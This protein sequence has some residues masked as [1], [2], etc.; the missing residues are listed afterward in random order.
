MEN[1]FLVWWTFRNCHH[2]AK[3]K[4]RFGFWFRM[5]IVI[6]STQNYSL[7]CVRWRES[8]PDTFFFLFGIVFDLTKGGF[9]KINLKWCY[10]SGQC[11]QER[12]NIHDF[13]FYWLLCL[14]SSELLPMLN[15]LKFFGKC[16]TIIHQNSTSYHA[17]MLVKCGNS[18][19]NNNSQK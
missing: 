19:N 2:V 13:N 1:R 9:P 17:K 14:F 10:I 15:Q 6:K 11:H 7:Y 16:K 12:K 3:F 5:Q 8:I 4:R 18:S